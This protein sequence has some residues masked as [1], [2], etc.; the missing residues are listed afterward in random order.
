MEGVWGAALL[1][2][3]FLGIEIHI[4]VHSPALLVNIQWTK[5]LS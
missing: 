2:F 5:N 1:Y 4:L 3:L